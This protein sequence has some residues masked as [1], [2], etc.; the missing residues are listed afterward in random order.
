MSMISWDNN[1]D[2]TEIRYDHTWNLFFHHQFT[3]EKF[4]K[5]QDCLNKHDEEYT[6]K[7]FPPKELVF[8]AFQ[9]VPKDKIKVVILGQDP[10]INEGEA[11]GLSFSVPKGVKIP[12][13][14]RNIYKELAE[15]QDVDFDIPDHGDLTKWAEQGVL[16]LNSALTVREGKSNSHAEYWK[17]MTDNIIKDISKR[18]NGVI[19]L[20][21]GNYARHKKN[22]IDIDKHYVLESVHPSPLSAQRGG[23]FGSRHFSKVNK[24]LED[25]KKTKIEW[26]CL[27]KLE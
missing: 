25:L 12:P 21:W 11:M 18:M 8:N 13:S 24:I 3:N 19:F 4:K 1:K 16:L 6:K 5:L 14:L 22:F 26:N 9:L 20:L 15:D 27:S 17:Y 10:Y 7:I 23:W 2:I